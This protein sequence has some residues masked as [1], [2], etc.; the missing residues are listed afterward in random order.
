MRK[1]DKSQILSK[2][3]REWLEDLKDREHPKYYSNHKYYFDIKMSLLFCQKGLCAY[4]EKLLCDPRFIT[5]DN[6]NNKK[7]KT[8]LTKIEKNSIQGDME[9]FD[10]SL[11]DKKGWLW[12]NLFIVDTHINCRV[13]G[14]KSIK[15]ILKPDSPDY[16]PYRYL[17]FFID[18]DNDV[19]I[20]IP[21]SNLSIKEQRDVAYMIETLGLNCIEYHRKRE[22][23]EWLDRYSFGLPVEPYEYLTA[24]KMTL[25][26][27]IEKEL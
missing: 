24:W 26:R 15:N 23:K 13:K 12:D 10:E 9:H 6:W 17:E 1:I 20:F 5:E 4:T 11:K 25:K 2:D 19:Y 7:Y 22:L 3:Y 27:W 16:D 14:K 8:K 21:N 18:K